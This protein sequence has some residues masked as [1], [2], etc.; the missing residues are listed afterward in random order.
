MSARKRHT[1]QIYSALFGALVISCGGP[2]V[3][4]VVPAPPPEAVRAPEAA[5]PLPQGGLAEAPPVVDAA[6]A[7]AP[8]IASAPA[9]PPKQAPAPRAAPPPAPEAPPRRV[10]GAPP[11]TELVALPGGTVPLQEWKNGL[12]TACAAAKPKRPPR[13]LK[14]DIHYTDS[15]GKT[16]PEQPDEN[17]EVRKQKPDMGVRVP[18]TEKVILFVRCDP[19]DTSTGTGATKNHQ[20][21]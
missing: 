8:R 4:V 19:L 15:N 2:P 21:K 20:G 18:T 10:G 5:P 6:P 16:V 3:Y 12:D 1:R 9:A 14:L 7:P 17:C 13:C 11:G